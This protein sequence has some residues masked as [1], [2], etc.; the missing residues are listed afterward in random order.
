MADN[1]SALQTAADRIR[2]TAKW[3]TVSFAALGAIM[4]AGSQ[5]SSIGALEVGSDRFSAAVT[6]GI[7]ATLGALTILLAV[8]WTATNPAI[9]LQSLAQKPPKGAEDV[10]SDRSLLEGYDNAEQ[11]EDD[12]STALNERKIAFAAHYA[13]PEV[14]HLKTAAELADARAVH[15]HAIGSNLVAV[16]SYSAL[17]HRWRVTVRWIVLGALLSAFGLGVFAWA[18]NP[19]EEAKASTAAANVLATPTPQ[20]VKLTATGIKALQEKLGDNCKTAENINVL[21][22]A[23]TPSGPDVLVETIDCARIRVVMTRAWGTA[24]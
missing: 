14:V 21:V 24:Q 18:A 4:V 10:V 3:L 19:P 8:A 17:S 20:V 6:G 11:V 5:L 7:V 1:A 2:E 16:A 23:N 13:D 22:L 9:T 12:Y 15:I